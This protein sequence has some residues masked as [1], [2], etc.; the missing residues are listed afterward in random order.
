M[1]EPS[2]LT[3]TRAAYDTMAVR[4]TEFTRD[5]LAARPLERALLAA[6]AELVGADGGGRVLDVGCGNGR[7]ARHL[8]DL[9]LDVEG[10][11]LSPGMITEARRLHP[12]LRF[13]VGSMLA[14]DVPDATLTGLLAWYSVIH[15][16]DDLLPAVFTEFHRVLA[17][18]GHL[19]LGFQVGDEH[20]H[21]TDAWGDP[22]DVVFHRRRPDD[23]AQLLAAAGLTTHAR[24][25]R[26][27]QP[28]P[29]GVEPTA[30]A[31]LLARRPM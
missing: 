19:L 6:F 1:T 5:E 13:T 7:V 23:V 4:Y 14:L 28:W 24:L 18:G 29:G 9:G 11:D 21:R 15:V 25:H 26:E 17:P 27:P 22:V 12:D 10:V 31:F 8:R 20:V 30:Q 3:R 16:P 2:F